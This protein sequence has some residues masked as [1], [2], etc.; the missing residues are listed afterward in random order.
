MQGRADQDGRVCLRGRRGRQGHQ[1]LCLREPS[2]HDGAPRDR[3]SREYEGQRRSICRS[4]GLFL[5]LSSLVPLPSPFAGSPPLPSGLAEGPDLADRR[6]PPSVQ[7]PPDRGFPL[8]RHEHKGKVLYQ[9]RC[10]CQRQANVLPPVPAAGRDVGKRGRHL[11]LGRQS[12]RPRARS[13]RRLSPPD[14][15]LQRC[16]CHLVHAG[17]GDDAPQELRFSLPQASQDDRNGRLVSPRAAEAPLPEDP[18]RGGEGD[19]EALAHAD[20]EERAAPLR[21]RLLPV[22]ALA[23]RAHLPAARAAG[24]GQRRRKASE[25]QQHAAQGAAS[26]PGH[27]GQ[28]LQG[29][30]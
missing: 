1:A 8:Y 20:G 28:L 26:V 9:T 21:D 27:A 4:S 11:V 29:R 15:R 12:F 24:R 5:T 10:A 23:A 2:G 25:D 14:S 22:V 30:L 16:A 18:F 6:P 19:R 7:P 3:R 13:P 17:V